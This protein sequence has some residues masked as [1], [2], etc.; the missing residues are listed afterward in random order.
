MTQDKFGPLTGAPSWGP[1]GPLGPR[2]MGVEARW[3]AYYGTDGAVVASESGTVYTITDEM[4][5]YKEVAA[6]IASAPALL[7]A[8]EVVIQDFG[9][10]CLSVQTIDRMMAA[11]DRARGVTA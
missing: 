7:A 1:N 3:T 2:H 6:L 11:V 8:L 5:Q 4:N 9:S 10:H